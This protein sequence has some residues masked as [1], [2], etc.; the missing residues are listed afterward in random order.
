MRTRA[1]LVAATAS[2]LGDSYC[3]LAWGGKLS[4]AADAE[5]AAAVLAGDDSA[6]A[7]QEQALAAWARIVTRDPNSTTAGDVTALRQAGL[8]DAQIMAVTVF[9]ALRVAFSTVN[10]AL[11]AVPDTELIASVPATVADAVTWGRR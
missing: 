6:L 7:P 8:D 10:D 3:A 9:V 11:G 5:L 1:I 2:T 4:A